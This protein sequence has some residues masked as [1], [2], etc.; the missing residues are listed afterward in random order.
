M[1][2]VP[3]QRPPA[4]RALVLR[5]VIAVIAIDVVMFLVWRFVLRH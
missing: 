5:V 1:T 2:I 4:Q 3:Q